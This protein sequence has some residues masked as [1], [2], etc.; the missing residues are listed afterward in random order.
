MGRKLTLDKEKIEFFKEVYKLKETEKDYVSNTQIDILKY[1]NMGDIQPAFVYSINPL[2]IACFTDEFD[3]V[4]LLSYPQ[5]YIEK[6]NLKENDKLVTSNV[7]W[8]KNKTPYKDIVPGILGSQRYKDIYPMVLN[9]LV[10]EEDEIVE[11]TKLFSN[12]IWEYFINKTYGRVILLQLP[13][14]DGMFYFFRGDKR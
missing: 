11:Y 4:I 7:Y 5:E 1:I 10:S 8:A 3:D 2:I 13:P 12:Y 14:R 6:Y 9:F